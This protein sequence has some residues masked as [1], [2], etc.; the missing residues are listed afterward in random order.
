M[1]VVLTSLDEAKAEDPVS[2]DLTGK[3]TIGDHMVV[4]TGRSKT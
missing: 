4:A 1:N 2:I 3:T